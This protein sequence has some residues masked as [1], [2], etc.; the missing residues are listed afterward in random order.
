M[1]QIRNLQKSFGKVEALKG[2]SFDVPS[3]AVVGVLGPNGAGKST[4]IRILTGAIPPTSGTATIDGL[5]TIND[6]H[7]VRRKIGYL[8]EANPLYPEMRARDYLRFRA[9][10][11]GIKG[12]A[13]TRSV[14][15]ALERCWLTDVQKRRA[16]VLSKGYRQRLGLAAALVHDPPLLILDEPTSGLDPSQIVETRALIR[17]LAGDH[18]ML[19]VSHILPEVERT[20]DTVIVFSGGTI[21]AQGSPEALTAHAQRPIIH[22]EAQ[23]GAAESLKGLSR[24]TAIAPPERDGDWERVSLHY[25]PD[26]PDPEGAVGLHLMNAGFAIRRLSKATASLESLYIALTSGEETTTPPTSQPTTTGGAP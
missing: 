19:L 6:S 5:D 20:C 22:L 8:P 10:L 25:E 4:T 18:T 21:R 13:A 2:V 14:D 17:E 9:N 1:I 3:G 16:G 7:Q 11:Y 23:P 26:H 12:K 24:I 15:R